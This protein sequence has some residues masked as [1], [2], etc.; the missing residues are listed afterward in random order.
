MFLCYQGSINCFK[1]G[2]GFYSLGKLHV[3]IQ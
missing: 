3:F 1:Q 2:T